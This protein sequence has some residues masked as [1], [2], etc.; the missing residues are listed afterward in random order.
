M[1]HPLVKFLYVVWYVPVLVVLTVVSGA[2]AIA[3]SFFSARAGRYISNSVWG[4]IAL[5]PAGIRLSISGR[6]NLPP[7]SAGGFIVFA[8][9]T[10][11][12]DIPTVALGTGRSV[13]WVAKAAL[14]R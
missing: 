7:A 4:H 12:A 14:G 9:H 6:E 8:N 5:D 3:A 2:A 13:S 10:S 1:N 11:M